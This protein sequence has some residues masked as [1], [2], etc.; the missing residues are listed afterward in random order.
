MGRGGWEDWGATEGVK[1]GLGAS[2]AKFAFPAMRWCL[3]WGGGWGETGDRWRDQL[4][5]ED[6]TVTPQGRWDPGAALMGSSRQL[7]GT[8]LSGTV[9]TGQQTEAEV[10]PELGAV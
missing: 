4:G 3:H 10:T 7:Q 1:G 2:R 5:R 6:P 8:G 9:L